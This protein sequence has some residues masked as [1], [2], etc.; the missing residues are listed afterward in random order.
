MSG[1][2]S[3]ALPPSEKGTRTVENIGSCSKFLH[4]FPEK[5]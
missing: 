5:Q 3:L 4:I 2:T 1:I